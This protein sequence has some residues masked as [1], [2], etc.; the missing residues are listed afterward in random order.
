MLW[1]GSG[2]GGGGGE[3]AEGTNPH[4]GEQPE[5]RPGLEWTWGGRPGT[6]PRRAQL[7]RHCKEVG[8]RPSGQNHVR[9]NSNCPRFSRAGSIYQESLSKNVGAEAE[10]VEAGLSFDPIWKMPAPVQGRQSSTASSTTL[11][12]VLSRQPF[13]LLSQN[14]RRL[15]TARGAKFSPSSPPS[16][17][18]TVAHDLQHAPTYPLQNPGSQASLP[19]PSP[20]FR[21]LPTNLGYSPF[22]RHIRNFSRPWLCRLWT[23]PPETTLHVRACADHTSFSYVHAQTSHSMKHLWCLEKEFL[24]SLLFVIMKKLYNWGLSGWIKAD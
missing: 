4:V 23:S 14:F 20:L 10:A 7:R 17:T 13:L 6:D 24:W 22:L 5:Q 19:L 21:P 9:R 16:A 12:T 18:C 11:R 1:E 8:C 3:G 2:G 15:P